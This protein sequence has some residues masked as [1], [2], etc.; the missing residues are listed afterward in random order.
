MAGLIDRDSTFFR[1]RR[2]IN[3][4]NRIANH[5]FIFVRDRSVETN[6]ID[7][8]LNIGKKDTISTI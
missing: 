1:I 5:M 3:N 4:H 8:I 6:A 2:I 7:F